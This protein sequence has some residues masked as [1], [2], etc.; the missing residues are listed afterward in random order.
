VY[1]L[2]ADVAVGNVHSGA[3]A[4]IH[5]D[6]ADGVALTKIGGP[7]ARAPLPVDAAGAGYPVGGSGAAGDGNRGD[8]RGE[9][10]V[11]APGRPVLAEVGGGV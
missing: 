7:G 2:Y 3:A 9:I 6:V 11:E 1:S 5:L 8:K 10:G 4:R